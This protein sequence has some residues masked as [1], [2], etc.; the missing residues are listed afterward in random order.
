MSGFGDN[1]F[2][3]AFLDHSLLGASAV[4]I[5]AA[6]V[7][8]FVVARGEAFAAHTLSM[9]AFPGGAFAALAGVPIAAGLYLFSLLAAFAIVALRARAGAGRW[10]AESAL[11]GTVQAAALA[12]GFLALALYGGVLEDLESLLFGSPFGISLAAAGILVAL[13]AVVIVALAAFGRPL[14]FAS[15]DADL[16]RAGGVAVAALEV[17]FAGLLAV[18]V[19]ATAQITGVLLVFALLLAPAAVARRLFAAP[20]ASVAA[21][22]LL[23][24]ALVWGTLLCSFYTNLPPGFLAPAFAVGAYLPVARGRRARRPRSGEVLVVRP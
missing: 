7:G 1:P 10:Q 9:M 19:A 4:A 8:W 21:A 20:A 24:V 18:A 17:C 16:A 2:A 11:I 6:L 3:Y 23:G 13:A 14:L 5:A 22:V 15:L 12:L